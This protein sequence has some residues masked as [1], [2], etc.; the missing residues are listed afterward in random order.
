MHTIFTKFHIKIP[1]RQSTTVTKVEEKSNKE[2]LKLEI[3]TLFYCD[4]NIS[5]DDFYNLFHIAR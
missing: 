2:P 1:S 4:I 5:V 3:I